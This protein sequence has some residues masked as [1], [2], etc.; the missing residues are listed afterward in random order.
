MFQRQK[1]SHKVSSPVTINVWTKP[2]A[3]TIFFSQLFVRQTV[4]FLVAVREQKNYNKKA[5]KIGLV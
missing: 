2:N 1:Y 4:P 5:I 3:N